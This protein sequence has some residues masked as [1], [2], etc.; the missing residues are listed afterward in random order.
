MMLYKFLENANKN[1]FYN[2]VICLKANGLMSNMFKKK[3]IKVIYINVNSFY[4]LLKSINLIFQ[5][6]KTYKPNVV[7]SWLHI[8]DL[9]AT[10]IKIRF[11]TIKLIWNLRCSAPE[12][13]ILGIRSWALVK[14]LCLLSRIPDCVIANSQTGI[15]THIAAGYKPKNQ[16]VLYNGFDLNIFKRNLKKNE[17]FRRKHNIEETHFIIGYVGKKSKIK[18]LDLFINSIEIINKKINNLKFIFLGNG[19]DKNN[20]KLSKKL[21][22]INCLHNS[23]LLGEQDNVHNI[24]SSFDIFSI[25]SLSEGFPNVL[26]EAMSA[27]VPCVVTNVGDCKF[28][29]GDAGLAINS[30]DPYETAKAWEN[31]YNMPNVKRRKIGINAR[32]IVKSKFNIKKIVNEY[33]TLIMDISNG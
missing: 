29:I 26:G 24:I 16:K 14:L 12:V 4:H 27:E 31:L 18:G 33:E 3:N 19:L 2:I 1:F 13:S 7:M 30:F 10:L 32:N 28:I 8:S 23:I 6:I 5:I 22:N 11:P 15:D 9:V 20:V 25:T 21:N 17:A